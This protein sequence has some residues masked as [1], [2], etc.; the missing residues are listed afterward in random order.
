MQTSFGARLYTQAE[1][2]A[3]L[4]RE[5]ER[6]ADIAGRARQVPNDGGDF[7]NGWC[8]ASA[9]I[10]QAIRVSAQAAPAVIAADWPPAGGAWIKG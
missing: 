5:R 1:L 2:E 6:C 4:A 10:E 9:Q 8:S 3:A 7:A